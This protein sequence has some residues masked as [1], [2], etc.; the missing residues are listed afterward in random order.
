MTGDGDGH[1]CACVCSQRQ[2]WDVNDE[3]AGCLQSWCLF[4][5]HLSF[6]SRGKELG[7]GRAALQ[8][9]ATRFP[10]P[11][12]L[13]DRQE[14][15]PHPGQG[16][17]PEPAPGAPARAAGGAMLGGGDAGGGAGPCPAAEPAQRRSCPAKRQGPRTE[18][19][20]RSAAARATA[21]VAAA[22][23]RCPRCSA[24]PAA[25]PR[26]P[27]GQLPAPATTSGQRGERCWSG[28]GQ[29]GKEQAMG[30]CPRTGQAP[31]PPPAAG[32]GLSL[33]LP[34]AGPV[35]HTTLSQTR[36]LRGLF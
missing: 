17:E 9:G 5:L 33:P 31:S 28:A 26:S 27:Q 29:L 25:E 8:G 6:E 21:A 32:T 34:R 4:L 35:F 18:P 10:A 22:A 30:Q 36:L 13:T 15:L 19:R 11:E 23:A 16:Q 12:R 2:G 24:S 1:C 14:R 3:R 7:A 20:R